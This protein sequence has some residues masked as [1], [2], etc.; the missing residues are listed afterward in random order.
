[1]NAWLRRGLIAT[2]LGVAS[3][4]YAPVAHAQIAAAIGKPLPSS[5]LPAGTLSVRVIAGKVSDPVVG[6]DVTLVVNGTPRQARTDAGGRASFT[7]LPSGATVQAKVLDEDK[8][9][10]TSEEFQLSTESGER[11]LLST[12]PFQAPVGGA[13]FAGGGGGGMPAPRQISGEPRPEANDQPGTYTVR[14][15]YNDLADKT[16]PQGQAVYLVGYRADDKVVVLQQ[17][18]DAAG[19][20]TFSNLDRTGATSYFAMTELPR[21]SA[22]VID[23]LVSTPAVLDSRGGVRLILSGAKYDSTDPAIDDINRIEKQD[24]APEA[25]KIRVLLMGVPED[26][27]QVSLVAMNAAGVRRVIASHGATRAAADPK[28]IQA[29]SSFTPKPDIPAHG[30]RVQVHGGPNQDEPI[31]G[32]TIRIVPASAVAP[33]ADLS[34]LGQEVKTPDGG[35]VDVTDPSTEPLIASYTVNGKE[36]QSQPFD[37]TKQGGILDIEAHWDNQGRVYADFDSADVKP[38]EVVFAESTMRKQIYRSIPFQPFAGHGT[39]ATLYVYPRIMFS[40]E[41]SSRIDDEFLA[42]GGKFNLTNNS[43]APYVGSSDGLII[44]LPAHFKGAR[45]GEQ[46]QDDVAVAQGEGFRI[47]R[48]IPPGGKEFHGQFSMPIENGRVE[49][50]LDLPLGAFQS[51]MEILQTPG[52]SVQTPSS[53]RGQVMT[54]PQGTFY[55]LPQISILPHQSMQMTITNLPSQ[56]AWKTWA[57]RL[58]GVLGL[59][60]MLGGLA[61]ALYRTSASRAA[62]SDRAAKKNALLDELVEL[63]KS[64]KN[65]KRRV[66][67]ASELERL[68]AD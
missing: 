60:T 51:G 57:P 1:M 46:D 37:L 47:G 29:S 6:V 62:Q 58:V 63:E 38:D 12:K 10:V 7:N 43:W 50:A 54:V 35:L 68:W 55:V 9:D 45:V 4:A 23:R 16:P 39:K 33:G 22:G 65:E 48:P 36:N 44:P 67:I 41:W 40:F 24:L 13:P 32:V 52:M 15:T 17:K 28:D 42:V 59:L 66:Q 61:L 25:G 26:G 27:A 53:V 31:G 8:K 56:P 14:L 18:S 11:L 30:L 19:R 21:A 20:A 5:D 2:L 49:W 3:L 34:K 64:G